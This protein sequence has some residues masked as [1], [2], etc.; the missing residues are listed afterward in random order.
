MRFVVLLCLAIVQS[1]AMAL[2]EVSQAKYD[3]AYSVCKAMVP[4]GHRDFSLVNGVGPSS[5]ILGYFMSRGE[6]Y[7]IKSWKKTLVEHP[8]H[9]ELISQPTGGYFYYPK[10]GYL[11]PDQLSWVVEAQG[12]K[13]K[14]IETVWVANVAPEYGGCPDDYKLPP[15]E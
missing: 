5:P 12:K 2:P 8:K 14:V 4:V 7:D 11:G 6:A 13:F 9:G 1:N 3:A 10:D 15:A